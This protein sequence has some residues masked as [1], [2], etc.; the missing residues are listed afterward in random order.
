MVRS[1][2]SNPEHLLDDDGYA[3]R[4]AA[5]KVGKAAGGVLG[6]AFGEYLASRSTE[7]GGE[8]MKALKHRAVAKK[9]AKKAGKKAGK[10]AAK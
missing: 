3:A 2:R 8:V 5:I 4:V 1:S 7:L 6:A 9:P 10:K